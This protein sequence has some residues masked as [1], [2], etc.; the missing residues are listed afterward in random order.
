MKNYLLNNGHIIKAKDESDLISQMNDL[1]WFNHKPSNVEYM[2]S[3]AA[4]CATQKV[5]HIRY[6]TIRNFIGD[7][8]ENGFIEEL[9]NVDN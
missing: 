3:T 1:S 7:L 6:D 9:E 5:C 4:L 2:K 8:K